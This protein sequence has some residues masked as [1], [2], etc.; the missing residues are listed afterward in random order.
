MTCDHGGPRM[1]VRR[2]WLLAMV[3]LSLTALVAVIRSHPVTYGDH[4]HKVRAVA[5]SPDGKTIASA[6]DDLGIRVWD[7]ATG[8]LQ[9]SFSGDA[10]G[11]KPL[12]V[13]P[14][15]KLIAAGGSDKVVRI[16]DAATGE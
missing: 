11:Y 1:S 14:D 12:A 13:S 10:S 9:S 2:A 15:G 8:A 6:S 7:V 5:A 16:W 3:G 4:L